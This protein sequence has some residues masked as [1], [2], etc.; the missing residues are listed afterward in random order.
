[1]IN[2]LS[3]GD[4]NGCSACASICPTKCITMLK[5]A[6]GFLYPS[7]SESECIG[8]SL[9]EKAC[10]KA[11]ATPTDKDTA[12]FAV[13]AKEDEVRRE[14]SSGGIFSLLAQSTLDKGGAVFGA[15]LC[16]DMKVRHVCVE[17]MEDIPLLRGSK[18][19]Q[20]E[21]GD[22]YKRAKD[23]LSEGR[24]VLFSG[25]PCQVGGLFSFLGR[26]Y[27]NLLC[28]DIVCHGVPSPYAWE[29]Y[30]EMREEKARATAVGASFRDKSAGWR[31]FSMRVDF[32]DGKSYV[33]SH[34]DDEYMK[35]FLSNLS[36]RPSCYNCRF[37][38]VSRAADMTLADF[39]GV[40]K[41]LPEA[42]DANGVSLVLAHSEK[43]RRILDSI[44]DVV[45]LHK[46]PVEDSLKY[47]RAATESVARP[48]RRDAFMKKLLSSS[49]DSSLKAV[50]DPVPIRKAKN[51]AK[52]I[53]RRFLQK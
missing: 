18:Y 7:V 50:T 2:I 21:I 10:E 38:G 39:W 9:C 4:C 49:F 13:R 15:S 36:L 16:S 41:V 32:S 24:E 45:T 42:D 14:S 28:V 3:K 30:L 8:C 26:G 47:N 34:R 27:D 29:K 43:A 25:T 12:A 46:A 51:L 5:D 6:E 48:K 1:M 20:S 22:S 40:D 11:S 23:I 37:K 52:K 31:D 33:G 53:K 44:S 19:V 17:R 35:A